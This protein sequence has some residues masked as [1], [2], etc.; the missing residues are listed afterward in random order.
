MH[1]RKFQI[2]LVRPFIVALVGLGLAGLTASR[3]ARANGSEKPQPYALIYGTVWDPDGHPLYG[4]KVKVRR[5][6]DKPGKARW[7]LYSNHTGEFAQRVPVGNADYIVWADLKGYKLASG[8]TLKP[9]A[10]VT[11]HID[12]DERADIGLHLDW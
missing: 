1:S 10:E 4:V 5:A 9:G 7:E 6:T 8:K 3:G 2:N 12:N 11:V